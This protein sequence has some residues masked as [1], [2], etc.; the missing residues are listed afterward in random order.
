MRLEHE[1][2]NSIVVKDIDKTIVGDEQHALVKTWM[3][4]LLN[5]RIKM[6]T[7]EAHI[8]RV[9]RIIQINGLKESRRN[10][11]SSSSNPA[12]TNEV[13]LPCNDHDAV[14]SL[15]NA[16][17]QQ[18]HKSHPARR[19]FSDFKPLPVLT[20]ISAKVISWLV[21]SSLGLQHNDRICSP[22]SPN[23]SSFRSIPKLPLGARVYFCVEE[24]AS[25]ARGPSKVHVE[26]TIEAKEVRARED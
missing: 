4:N 21:L 8:C 17:T 5:E 10:R 6:R 15:L 7:S 23:S 11:R 14:K 25:N 20:L 2:D 13:S 19:D 18:Q 24:R 16:V 3:Q 22:C 1:C 26:P 9:T 12:S